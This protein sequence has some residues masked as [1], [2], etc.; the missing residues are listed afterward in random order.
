MTRAPAEISALELRERLQRD[1]HNLV[2]LDCREPEEVAVAR[3]SGTTHI[4]MGDIPA[5]C[6]EL[7]PDLETVVYCHHGVRSM[8]VAVWLL[9]QAGFARVLSLRGGI[10]AWSREVDPTV[11][12]Y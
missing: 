7:D 11:P 1:G 2:V 4:P 3:I 6:G 10:D 8:K 12:R 9:E 5:R